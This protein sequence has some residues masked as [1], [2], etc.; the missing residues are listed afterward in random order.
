M[1][2]PPDYVLGS[3]DAEIARLDGQASAI[4]P[5]TAL[6]LQAAGIG[7]G[8]R[9][10]DVGAG[11]GHGAFAAAAPVD[12]GGAVVGVDQPT[13]MLEV[14]EARRSAAGLGHVRFEVGDAR[15]FKAAEPFD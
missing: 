12:R 15:A 14:A 11:L 1:D 5:P 10:L 6:L 4:G 2:S 13:A 7:P 8:M 3:D 9:V